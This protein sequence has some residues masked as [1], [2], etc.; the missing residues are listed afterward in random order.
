MIRAAPELARLE[1]WN[2]V[3]TM[4]ARYIKDPQ[5]RQAFSFHTLL[6]GG[7]PF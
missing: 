5:L 2:S 4:V 3:H 1:S 6:V 7:D